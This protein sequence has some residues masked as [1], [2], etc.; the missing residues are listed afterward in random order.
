MYSVKVIYYFKDSVIYEMDYEFPT[1]TQATDFIKFYMPD[2]IDF[3][4]LK[5]ILEEL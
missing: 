2:D 1:R 4:S 5:Y 3:T